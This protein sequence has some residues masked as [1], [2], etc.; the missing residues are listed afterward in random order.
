MSILNKDLDTFQFLWNE[1][2]IYWNLGHFFVCLKA[3]ARASW[4]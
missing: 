2:R 1:L 4:D 3:M